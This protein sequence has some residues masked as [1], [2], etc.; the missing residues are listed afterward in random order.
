MSQVD[1]IG[2]YVVGVDDLRLLQDVFNFDDAA[3][4][5][6]LLVFRFLVFAVFAEIPKFPGLFYPLSD[7]VHQL[8][9]KL[10]QLIIQRVEPLFSQV[11]DIFRFCHLCSS[12]SQ[13]IDNM[14]KLINISE[15]FVNRR[16]PDVSHIIQ[17][18]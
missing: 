10:F 8:L 16:E 17:L 18:L 12:F 9:T 13:F 11:D 7:F 3:I 1:D 5:P 15:I 14:S 4:D 6:P 2:L